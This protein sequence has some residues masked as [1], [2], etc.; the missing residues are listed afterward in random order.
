ME[1][2]SREYRMHPIRAPV[3]VMEMAEQAARQLCH[4]HSNR[5]ERMMIQY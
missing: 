2:I 1:G 5:K 4:H 3:A